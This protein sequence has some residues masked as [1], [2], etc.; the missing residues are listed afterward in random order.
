VK[1][2]G[3]KST[4][5]FVVIAYSISWAIWLIGIVSIDGLTR[6]ET[7]DSQDFFW[8]AVSARPQPRLWWPA[9]P[10]GERPLSAC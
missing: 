6:I 7:R 10:A 1:N 3:I 5:A 2:R 8:Q 4:L 9:V